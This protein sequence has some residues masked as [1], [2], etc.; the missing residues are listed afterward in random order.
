VHPFV[1]GHCIRDA[2]LETWQALGEPDPFRVVELG[3][4][5]GTLGH[6]LLEAFGELPMPRV[7]YVGVEISPGAREALAGRGLAAVGRLDELEPFE[8]VV[9]ANELLDNLPFVPARGRASGTVEVR[10]GLGADGAL[11]EVEVPWARE[12]PEPPTLADGHQSTVPVHAFTLLETV[13]TR[14]RRGS[15]LL[16]DYGSPDGPGGRC[17]DTATTGRSRCPVRPRRHRHHRRR[18]LDPRRGPCPDVRVPGVRTDQAGG[19]ATG[20]RAR[21]VG[22]HDA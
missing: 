10:I 17:A 16:I 22:T 5:D 2:L 6:A 19:G 15:V 4:G 21:A 8:G 20:A 11:I 12:S 9:L 18:R 7:D 1:F 14:L 13:A 3:A